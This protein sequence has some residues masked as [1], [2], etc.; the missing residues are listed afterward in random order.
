M[1]LYLFAVVAGQVGKQQDGVL[2]F[3]LLRL[4]GHRTMVD[5]ASGDGAHF[6][7][8]VVRARHCRLY[9]VWRLLARAAHWHWH[10][11]R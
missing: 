8:P 1:K 10:S 6:G 4:P 2:E 3:V 11:H 9:N 7:T 5:G